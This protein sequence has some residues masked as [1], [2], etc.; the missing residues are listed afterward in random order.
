MV[1]GMGGGGGVSMIDKFE[2][3]P[4]VPV[5]VCYDLGKSLVLS[6]ST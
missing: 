5:P 1:H 2:E 3:V 6:F 4:M